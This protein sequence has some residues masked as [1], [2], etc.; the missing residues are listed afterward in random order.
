MIT[1]GA[2]APIK[3]AARLLAE[4]S[5]S[6]LPVVDAAGALVGIISEADLLPIE[7]PTVQIEERGP[8]RRLAESTAMAV[9]GALEVRFASRSW[10]HL[11]GRSPSRLS[12]QFGRPLSER[13]KYRFTVRPR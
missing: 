5:I 4:H 3:D 11:R 1:V 2:D 13:E 10:S 6:A 7:T 9:P 12:A 8:N